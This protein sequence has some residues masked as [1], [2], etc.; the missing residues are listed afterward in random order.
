[1]TKELSR[2]AIVHNAYHFLPLIGEFNKD[3]QRN[4]ALEKCWPTRSCW[5]G[6][7]TSMLCE[8]V[9]NLVRYD[10]YRRKRVPVYLSLDNLQ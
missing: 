5:T 6:T 3:R 1:M 9:T 8:C 7:I 4:L 10:R 2:P